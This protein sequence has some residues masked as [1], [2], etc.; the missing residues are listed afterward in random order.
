[1]KPIITVHYKKLGDDGFYA[2]VVRWHE[3]KESE[4]IEFF[5][6]DWKTLCDRVL[7][8]LADL[9]TEVNKL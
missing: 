2:Q 7:F 5:S 9:E 6:E 1:M 8:K 4:E 3:E